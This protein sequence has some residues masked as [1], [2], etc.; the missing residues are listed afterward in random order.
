MIMEMRT[1]T[2]QSGSV[3]TVE[4]RS[5]QA[6]PTRANLSPLAAFWHTEV[7]PLERFPIR[8]AAH[9]LEGWP[10]NIR[11]FVT[12]QQSEI[13]LPA[14]FS[15]KVEPR[16]LG[17]LYEILT[18]TLK[19]GGIPG[20]I[21]RWS[22]QIAERIK[23]SP[24]AGAWYLNSADSTAGAIPE[25]T[26]LPPSALPSVSVPATKAS[27]RRAAASP[28]LPSNR[29]TCWSSPHPPRLCASG[30]N[31]RLAFRYSTG[32]QPQWARQAF[33]DFD[34]KLSSRLFQGDLSESTQVR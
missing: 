31:R 22:T 12:E 18:Y 9:K 4:E 6:L 24:L 33:D 23:L 8:A 28:A 20:L 5:G 25:P 30:R 21:D 2:V 14:P 15:P 29:R 7:G 13:F 32:G 10:P 3:A 34:R 11:E 1:Y 17:S 19:P 26:R 27:G 16:K